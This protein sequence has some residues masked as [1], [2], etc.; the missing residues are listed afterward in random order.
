MDPCHVNASVALEDAL[1]VALNNMDIYWLII[2]YKMSD[3]ACFF[4]GDF[5]WWMLVQ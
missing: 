2:N 5:C 4:D 1:D 3:F